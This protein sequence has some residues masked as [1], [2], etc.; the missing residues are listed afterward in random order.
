MKRDDQVF[1]IPV[2]RLSHRWPRLLLCALAALAHAAPSI[3]AQHALPLQGGP[4]GA[5]F[6]VPCSNGA[7]LAGFFLRAG[8]DI[9]A[10]SPI[11]VVPT[12]PTTVGPPADLPWHGGGGG[13]SRFVVC[14]HSAPAVT[15]MYTMSEGADTIVLNSI[16]L[17]CG[18]VAPGQPIDVRSVAIFDAPA[19]Y[20]GALFAKDPHWNGEYG[21]CDAGEVATGIRGRSGDLVDAVGLVCERLPLPTYVSAIGRVG[22]PSTTPSGPRMS[23]C[24]R[25][26]DAT[27]RNSPV[28]ADLMEQCRASTPPVGSIGRI[29]GTSSVSSRPQMSICERARDA[30]RRQSPAASNL[31]AQCRA[32]GG[33]P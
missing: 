23:L 13:S 2:H 16:H 14:P 32:S 27:Q 22:G 20:S 4:G 24:E 29:G 33:T 28:A 18:I 12:A 15:G 17:A 1:P 11:C 9:N 25:A 19:Y 7:V 6:E 21:Y 5:P 3:A 30:L 31:V 26:R 8:D 10:L